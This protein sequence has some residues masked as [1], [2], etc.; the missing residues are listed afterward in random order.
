VGGRWLRPR[1]IGQAGG[2]GADDGEADIGDEHRAAGDREDRHGGRNAGDAAGDQEGKACTRRHALPDQPGDQRQ[3]RVAVEIGR[4]A[5]QRGG[6]DRGPALAADGANDQRFG[7]IG[8]HQALEHEGQRQPLAEEQRVRPGIV[9]ELAAAPG[10]LPE[11]PLDRLGR[12]DARPRAA[13]VAEPLAQRRADVAAGRSA[14]GWQS[15]RQARWRWPR[16]S[17]RRRTE[18]RAS[19]R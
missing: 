7:Q 12:P 17:W 8:D 16:S 14:H 5:D 2:E 18:A 1:T 6:R 3:R 10:V 9:P 13:A 19:R 15:R 11:A 4:D